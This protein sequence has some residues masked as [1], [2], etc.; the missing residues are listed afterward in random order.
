MSFYDDTVSEEVQGWHDFY[1]GI[2]AE[3]EETIRQL[4]KQLEGE[5]NA[6]KERITTGPSGSD[7][8]N[9]AENRFNSRCSRCG[10]GGT[11]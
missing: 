6:N 10:K 8:S 3:K 7:Q 2:I 5:Q 4:E 9:R 1:Q 11:E